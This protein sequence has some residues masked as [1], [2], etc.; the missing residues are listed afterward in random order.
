MTN[1]REITTLTRHSTPSNPVT[2][3]R[4]NADCT[5]P[6][7][8]AGRAMSLVAFL[9][10]VSGWA[11][12]TVEAQDHTYGREH[13]G[14]APSG[15]AGGVMD[16]NRQGMGVNIRGGHVA[17]QTVGREDSASLFQVAPYVNIGD[18]LL[19]GDGRLTYAN[20]GGLAWSF[21]GGYRHYI[22]AWDTIFGINGYADRDSITDAHFRQWG[23]G[24]ELIG[25][26]WEARG[27]LYRPYGK[28]SELT[29]TRADADSAIF[30]GNQIQFNR[31]DT[32]S[33]ALE[34][35][36]A[37]IG[38]LLPGEFSERFDL[39]AFGGGYHYEGVGQDGF[40]GFSTRLQAD[41]GEWL[42]LGL[43]LTDDE[44][45][46]TNVSF[47]AI[48]HYGGF[49]SQE[50]TSRSAIQRMA[51]PV[52]RNLNIAAITTD[53][54]VGGQ[55]ASAADGT[56]LNIIHVNS[57]AAPGGTGTVDNPFNALSTG[58]GA[59][60]SDIVFV[61]AGSQFNVAP[62]NV[63]NLADDQ[64]L[65][66]EGLIRVETL[67]GS[68][69]ENRKVIN[70][71]ELAEIGPLVL[72]DSPTFAADLALLGPDPF[73]PQPEATPL[74]P[75]LERPMLIGTAGDAVRMGNRSR[76]GGFIIEAPTGNG[77]VIDGVSGTNIRDTLI[78]NA[79]GTGILVQNTIADSTTTIL[80]T[81]IRGA[82]GPA[83]HVNGG[84]GLIGFNSTSTTLDPA[85]G[86]I[87]NSSN[88]AVLI[89]NRLGGSVNMLG[90]TIDDIGGTGIVIRGTGVDPTRGNVT[91]DNASIVDS[92]STGIS[93]TNAEGNI[94][95]RNTVNAA[96]AIDNAAGDSV[97]IDGVTAGSRVTFE[98][99]TITNPRL[100]GINIDNLGGSFVF[101]RDLVI[102]APGAG[103]V[104]APA[105]SVANNLAT[106][107]VTFGR[108]V[109]IQGSLGRGIELDSNA[110]GSSFAIN[111][112]LAV[113]AAAAESLAIV[114][115]AGT[116]QFLGGTTISQRGDTGILISNSTGSV[117]FEN[118]TSVLNENLVNPTAVQI[119]DNESLVQFENLVVTNALLGGGVSM[120]NNVLGALGPGT[121]IFNN[122]EITSVGGVGF[123]GDNNT[124]IRVDDG[125]ISS[126]G[127]AAVNIANSGINI[128]L[129]SVNS[130][131]SPDFGISLVETNVAGRRSFR[132]LGDTT[133]PGF[134]TGGT[135]DTAAISGVN[136]QNAGQVS[137]YSM[138]FDNNNYGFFIRNS[139]LLEDDDQYLD[140]QFDQ[141]LDS[142]IRG[143]DSE[144]L[145]ILNIEDSIFDGNGDAAAAA[146]NPDPN[147]GF[148][149]VNRESIF[150]NYTERLNNEDFTL[151]TQ[152]DNPYTLNVER[153]SFA[154]NSDDIIVITN[155]PA[156]DDAFLDVNIT[157]SDFQMNDT[158]DIDPG[159]LSET[160][161]LMNWGGVA[162][163][164]LFNNSVSMNGLSTLESQTA[165]EIEMDSFTDELILD[166]VA[167]TIPISAQP[168]A[169]G[170]SVET[171]SVASML[172]SNNEF[173][174]SGE[175]STGMLFDLGPNNQ[176]A[177]LNNTMI[178]QNDGGTGMLFSMV[179]QPALF[180]IS[181]NNIGL[182][183]LAVGTNE[184]GILFR[185]VIGTP[186]LQGNLNNQIVLLNPGFIP[187]GGGIPS[188]IEVFFQIPRANGQ[189]LVNGGLVP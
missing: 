188:N 151:F 45:F 17:G 101:T 120:V 9:F 84:A 136:L 128:T 18:G 114:N 51:E 110:A 168:N 86:S 27:N 47:N 109:S 123:G 124:S 7:V 112:Q 31:I 21:G 98:N 41:V 81:M 54:V 50:H 8:C 49:K 102:G 58:L 108:S 117:S 154:D 34:G 138:T 163:V 164:N 69:V 63:V 29:G 68:F 97:L 141:V 176:T 91:I 148:L 155:S 36:D 56:P 26:T 60:D 82:A 132:V 79:G 142:D 130:S 22:T 156:A 167:N 61:H 162:R 39:R 118:G 179:E 66:G 4:A 158:L 172:I 150:L 83:F 93:I 134:G 181:G 72:P 2:G 126:I 52:R 65:F 20:E 180:T 177:I 71:I 46:N 122:I 32:V 135:I 48:L 125:N 146:G 175:N 174:M 178:F 28:R 152:F 95:F 87:I 30:V 127:A 55:I 3:E 111:G 131:A 161:F 16:I 13:V 14:S 187:G 23:V 40:N 185:T 189:I 64:S 160:A 133:L 12:S 96:T 153:T 15:A 35:F 140:L 183:D 116:A 121:M 170:I 67:G 103:A 129:E 113:T 106:G 6:T 173:T 19:F 75:I 59:P 38:W 157:D 186:S 137:L 145:V 88:E 89:E 100:G 105:I 24:A 143:I 184:I 74:D 11:Q 73:G 144:N 99:L 94:A 139:G 5:R 10:V 119:N 43:K 53:V 90:S 1:V 171:E 182:T 147:G 77:I 76:L 37:E 85:Y 159:D 165:F 104:A 166:I 44:V 80:D 25:R 169:V 70:T 42:E 33:E 62:E 78:S 107:D 92:T 149:T 57:N 115:N